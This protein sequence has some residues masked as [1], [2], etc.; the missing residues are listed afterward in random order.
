MQ[1]S[2]AAVQSKEQNAHCYRNCSRYTHRAYTTEGPD[3]GPTMF[4]VYPELEGA[5]RL[6]TGVLLLRVGVHAVGMHVT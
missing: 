5:A 4:R 3:G 6:G 2:L 1:E